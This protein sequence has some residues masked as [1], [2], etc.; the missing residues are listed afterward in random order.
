MFSNFYR[1]CAMIINHLIWHFQESKFQ[2]CI[3][4]CLANAKWRGQCQNAQ[5]SYH[6]KCVPG[7]GEVVL[8]TLEDLG[9]KSHTK[10]IN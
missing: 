4:S 2:L 7:I 8:V 10:V 5:I 6:W 9:L 3:I 1:S